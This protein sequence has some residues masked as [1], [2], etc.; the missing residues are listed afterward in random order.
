MKFRIK[1]RYHRY[2]PD[3]F[4]PWTHRLFDTLKDAH[5]Q[6]KGLKARHGTE[7]FEW[8]IVEVGK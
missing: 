1:V 6:L 3:L 2:A 8:K 4:Y 7:I 5:E